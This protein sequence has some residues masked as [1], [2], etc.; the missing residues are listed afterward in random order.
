MLKL[1]A[2]VIH[3]IY[4]PGS[5]IWFIQVNSCRF[6]ENFPQH[7]QVA[8]HGEIRSRWFPYALVPGTEHW[9]VVWQA[10]KW[11]RHDST[12]TDFLVD[13]RILP[14][15][16]WNSSTPSHQSDTRKNKVVIQCERPIGRYRPQ[17]SRCTLSR[18]TCIHLVSRCHLF[19]C[20]VRVST[21][22]NSRVLVV[23]TGV[24]EV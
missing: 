9:I 13:F 4:Y 22:P 12:V 5:M 17:N 14:S 18:Q 21:P 11:H 15:S 16:K 2:S 24:L 20:H 6:S 8:Q 3:V 10:I 19:A 1:A 7:R 23:S